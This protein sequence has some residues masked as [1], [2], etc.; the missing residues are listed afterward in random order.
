MPPNS[1][2]FCAGAM[3]SPHTASCGLR[4]Y[5]QCW[6]G[7][8]GYQKKITK[9]VDK[10][11]FVCYNSV[12]VVNRRL[13]HK[14]KTMNPLVLF[15]IGEVVATLVIVAVIEAKNYLGGK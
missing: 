11:F 7:F 2:P 3:R 1:A 8:E 10:R 6:R 9:R 13:T 12:K 14:E 5:S 4:F 15:I